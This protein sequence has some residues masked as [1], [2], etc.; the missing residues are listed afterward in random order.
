[1]DEQLELM[2]AADSYSFVQSDYINDVKV[3]TP[4]ETVSNMTVN[5]A[6]C[7]LHGALVYTN[8]A[9]VL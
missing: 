3:H 1:M 2:N 5:Q 4:C 6:K 9:S 8:F 7:T